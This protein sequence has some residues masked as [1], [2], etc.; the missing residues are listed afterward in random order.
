MIELQLALD[1]VDLSTA[2]SL[3]EQTREHIDIFE[4]GTPLLLREGLDAVAAVHEAYPRLQILADA[5]IVDGGYGE[6]TMLFEA[7]A[8][9]VTVLAVAAPQT[10]ALVTKAARERGGRVAADLIASADPT[11]TAAALA[12]ANVDIIC[13]HRAA[14]SGGWLPENSEVLGAVSNR[15]SK[16]KIMVAGGIGLDT[17]PAIRRLAPDIV[18]IGGS[19]V[20]APDPAAAARKMREALNEGPSGSP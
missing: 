8:D 14:D 4:I 11:E 12:A 13:V 5:K 10:L 15:G 6:A 7:G 18:V 19:I 9:I 20:G 16:V 1:F 17:L 2:L 3:V